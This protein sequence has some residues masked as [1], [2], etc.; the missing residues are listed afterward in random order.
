MQQVV[1]ALLRVV[2]ST[3]PCPQL[4]WRWGDEKETWVTFRHLFMVVHV[5]PLSFPHWRASIVRVGCLM[6][7]PG[8]LVPEPSSRAVLVARRTVTAASASGVATSVS[9]P[10]CGADAWHVG[11]LWHYLQAKEHWFLLYCLGW[12]I[13][14]ESMPCLLFNSARTEKPKCPSAIYSDLRDQRK[15]R[16]TKKGAGTDLPQKELHGLFI[17]VSTSKH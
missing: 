4:L 17:F 6:L 5:S 2:L 15:S 10:V 7:G 12:L 1:L 8:W 16:K 3:R 13:S 14:V 11:P 9:S